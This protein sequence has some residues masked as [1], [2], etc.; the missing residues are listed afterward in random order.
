MKGKGK[1]SRT[2]LIVPQFIVRGAMRH[3]LCIALVAGAAALTLAGPQQPRRN[4]P[5]FVQVKDVPGLPRVLLIGDSIS[6]QYTLGVRE[7]LN[8]TANLHRPAQNCRSTRQTLAE[9]DDYLDGGRWD[10]IHFNWGIHDITHLDSEGK[11]APPPEGKH[12]VPLDQYGRNTR[13]LVQRLKKTGARLIW[14]STT[15]IG[16][17]TESKGYRRDR[18]VTAYNA[19]AAKVMQDF[20]VATNNLYALVKLQAESLLS[21]GVHFKPEGAEA[22]AEAVAAAIRKQLIYKCVKL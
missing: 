13:T 3:A 2:Q 11:V 6:M 20:D 19:A 1:G 12:Q 18:D 22:L 7:L 9:L 14:A 16:R 15:P 10:V 4:D 17:Q 8:G 21:D 5:S